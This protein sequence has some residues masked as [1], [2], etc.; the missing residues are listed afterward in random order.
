MAMA[1]FGMPALRDDGISCADH[2]TDFFSWP[3]ANIK[4]LSPPPPIAPTLSPSHPTG[5]RRELG[6]RG[7][8][9]RLRSTLVPSARLERCGAVV[10][11]DGPGCQQVHGGCSG[12][13]LR[14]GGGLRY[15]GARS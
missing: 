10:P 8:E 12:T 11:V 7:R 9:L 15:C 3:L 6:V 13:W 14:I 4:S 1:I 5:G 2:Q